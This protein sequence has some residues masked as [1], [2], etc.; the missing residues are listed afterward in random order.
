[1]W[2]ER[3]GVF[4]EFPLDANIHA[5]MQ[6]RFHHNLNVVSKQSYQMRE[7]FQHLLQYC[8]RD[9]PLGNMS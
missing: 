8:K 7:E 1:M 2:E 9:A 6:S 5:I 4:T 3:L